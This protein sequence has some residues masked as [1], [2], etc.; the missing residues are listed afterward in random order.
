[1]RSYRQSNLSAT[2]AFSLA[3]QPIE[4][5]A[6][7]HQHRIAHQDIMPSNAVVDEHSRRFYVID[8]SLSK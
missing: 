1:V 7:L 2:Y 6:F 4:G 8:F 3:L 5:I